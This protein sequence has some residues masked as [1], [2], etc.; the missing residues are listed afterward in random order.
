VDSVPQE[1]GYPTIWWLPG[2]VVADRLTL[3]LPVDAPQGAEYR[4]I[5]GLYDPA[6]GERLPVADTGAD[7]VE[8]QSVHY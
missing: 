8:L 1:G 6:T 3:D 4:L 5:V 2:E 7:F